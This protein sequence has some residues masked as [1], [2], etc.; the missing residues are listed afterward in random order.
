MMLDWLARGM[1]QRSSSSTTS[2]LFFRSSPVNGAGVNYGATNRFTWQYKNS[3]PNDSQTKSQVMILRAS[4]NT[5]LYNV[6]QTGAQQYIDIALDPSLKLVPVTW[7]VRVWTR[8]T[9]SGLGLR[10][11]SSPTQTSQLCRSPVLLR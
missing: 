7:Q 2:R 9:S 8:R 11:G 10:H 6:T 4:D 5:S 1:L 3:D